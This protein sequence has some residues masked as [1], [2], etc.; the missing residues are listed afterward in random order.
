MELK[1]TLED[2]PE[3]VPE[4]QRK[5]IEIVAKFIP[6][7][8]SFFVARCLSSGASEG[9]VGACREAW[10]ILKNKEKQLVFVGFTT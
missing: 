8:L 10:Q 9:Y 5:I 7:N 1:S 3:N 4:N 2:L 6:K